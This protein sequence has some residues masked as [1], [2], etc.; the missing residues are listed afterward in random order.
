MR[1]GG[2]CGEGCANAID[3]NGAIGWCCGWGVGLVGTEASM[4]AGIANPA[5][6]AGA[7]GA[8]ASIGAS[9]IAGIT[10]VAAGAILRGTCGSW[11]ERCVPEIAW[12]ERCVPEIAWVERCV[13]ATAGSTSRAAMR[14]S[15]AGFQICCRT[16][17]RNPE[18]ILWENIAISGTNTM[19]AK[20]RSE[21][22]FMACKPVMQRLYAGLT[23]PA[24]RPSKKMTV[25]VRESSDPSCRPQSGKKPFFGKFP[26]RF[27]SPHGRP[28]R[29]FKERPQRLF[30]STHHPED[31]PDRS[32][33]RR[34]NRKLLSSCGPLKESRG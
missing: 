8:M 11:V 23:E 1:A 29:Y 30:G 12:V 33:E 24:Q 14:A 6:T 34:Q 19:Q 5:V 17:S 3:L 16:A 7:G 9:V 31:S 18:G 21:R 10:I 22:N 32:E 26:G 28:A 27:G 25:W 2:A 13:P 20:S 15:L 4:A